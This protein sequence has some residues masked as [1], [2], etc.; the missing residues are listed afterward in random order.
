[1]LNAVCVKPFDY[2]SIAHGSTPCEGA[3]S[4]NK[5]NYFITKYKI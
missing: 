5:I 1:M 3:T 2:K 4:L